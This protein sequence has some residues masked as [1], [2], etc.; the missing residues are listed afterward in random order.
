MIKNRSLQGLALFGVGLLTSSLSSFFSRYAILGSATDLV[1]GVLAGLAVVAYGV[2][3][4]MLHSQRG[5]GS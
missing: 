5:A 4:L 2:S 1:T 3:I